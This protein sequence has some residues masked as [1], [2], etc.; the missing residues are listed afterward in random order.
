MGTKTLPST[1]FQISPVVKKSF[2]LRHSKFGFQASLALPLAITHD[3]SYKIDHDKFLILKWDANTPIHNLLLNDSYH[4]VQSRFNVFLRP[5]IGIFYKLDERQ[6]ITLDA[7]RG[8][9][10]GGDII[11]R[12]LNE[13]VFEGTSY[14]STHRLSGNFTAVMLG[15]TYRL[16]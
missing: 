6:F 16:K 8:I 5:E 15:Y 2:H 9:K 13:I 3:E 4:Q 11:I 7:Q 10:P 14:Q 1:F 12:E